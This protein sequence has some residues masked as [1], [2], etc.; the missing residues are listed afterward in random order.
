[1]GFVDDC[2]VCLWLFDQPVPLH[3]SECASSTYYHV[4]L[5]FVEVIYNNTY[6]D[7][8][9][10]IDRYI[11]NIYQCFCCNFW[12][13]KCNHHTHPIVCPNHHGIHGAFHGAFSLRIARQ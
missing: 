13:L 4:D 1:M 11:Y 3:F 9:T 8:R 6:I 12:L 7:I 5:C 2:Y 10:Y